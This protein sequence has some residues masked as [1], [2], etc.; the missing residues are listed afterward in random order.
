[1]ITSM[2]RSVCG[3]EFPVNVRLDHRD[4]HVGKYKDEAYFLP[5]T[6]LLSVGYLRDCYTT[7]MSTLSFM[8]PEPPC[9]SLLALLNP[10]HQK[11]PTFNEWPERTPFAQ[12][13]V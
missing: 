3:A 1:M 12:L 5:I 8:W 2:G 13:G 9:S 4:K 6:R 11:S 10:S 7:G